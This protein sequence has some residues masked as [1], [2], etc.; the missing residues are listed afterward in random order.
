MLIK[1]ECNIVIKGVKECLTE[2]NESSTTADIEFLVETC[3]IEKDEIVSCSRAG[4][5][6]VNS[7]DKRF[8][9][10]L[11]PSLKLRKIIRIDKPR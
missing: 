2:D 8:P 5:K 9:D 10:H 6:I 7:S 4:K 1:R 11:L 3:E